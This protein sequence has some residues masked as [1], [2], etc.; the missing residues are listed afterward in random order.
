MFDRAEEKL[1]KG[2]S[3]FFLSYAHSPPLEGDGQTDPDEHVRRFFNDLTEAV[4]SHAAPDSELIPGLFDQDFPVGPDW[5]ESFS[6]ALGAAEVFVPLYSPGYFTRSWPGREWACFHQRLVLA[7]LKDPVR[8]FAPVLWTPLW[9][10]HGLP[11]LRAAM[12]VGASESE[13]EKSGLRALLRITS[14]RDSYR[15]VV[16]KLAERVVALAEESPLVPS[17]VPDID[18]MKSAFRP[19]ANL[20]VFA[21]AVAAPARGTVPAG[22]DPDCYGD[23]SINWRP[24]SGQERPLAEYLQRVAERL[25]FEVELTSLEEACD[26]AADRPGIILID[27]WFIADDQG[28]SAL[29]S[30]LCELPP[31][32]LPLLVHSSP[33]DGGAGQLAEQVRDMLSAAGVLPAES[34]RRASRSIRSLEAFVAIVPQLVAEAERRF[35]RY[36]SVPAPLVQPGM[37][38]RL[39][40][41]VQLAT[42]TAV[43]H[44]EG[45]AQD[46]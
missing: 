37:R 35:F 40:S 24:F 27:P 2:R 41:G 31:W 36:A 18:E 10:Q 11:G 43:P 39:S 46:A 12:E 33:P 26:P 22:S 8:R 19:E 23:S 29:W 21:V 17:A 1:S 3:Y 9:D 15:I 25:D 5:K 30:A 38:L 4:R 14:Y 20:A 42:P 45:D 32:V 16:N 7:G 6:R 13:Y 44:P 34:A 28:R